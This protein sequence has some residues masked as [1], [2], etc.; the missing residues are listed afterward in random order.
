MIPSLDNDGYLYDEA[1]GI[2]RSNHVKNGKLRSVLDSRMT[3]VHEM[4]MEAVRLS[5]D[6]Y[7]LGSHASPSEPYSWLTFRGVYER[8]CEFAS[9]LLG[10]CSVKAN[11]TSFLGIYGRN[12]QDWVISE[13]ACC[14]YNFV[15][16][17]LYDTLG[18]EALRH[19][20]THAELSVCICVTV[21]R[22]RNLLQLQL[23]LLK[24]I[25]LISPEEIDALRA[26]AGP[27]IQVH[28][29]DDI[30][31]YGKEH[32]QPPSPSEPDE[33][34]L[35]CYTSGT[36]GLPKGV[37]VTNKMLIATV[38]G[39]MIHSDLRLFTSQD[40]HL[41]YLPLAHIFE[42]FATMLV[43]SG[44]GRIGF[45]AGDLTQLQQDAFMLQPTLF[46][47]VP[48][49]LAR[50]KQKVYRQVSGS[51]FKLS[52]LNTAINRKLKEVDRRIYHHNTIWDQLVFS[53]IRKSFGSRIRIV[54][55]AG[56]PISADLLQFTR[57]AFCCPVLEGYGS[58]E[59]CGAITSSM[60]GDLGGGHVGPP[61]PNCEIKLC[62][63]E[64]LDLVSSRDNRGEIC[65][66]GAVCTPGYYKNEELT[67]TLIDEDG[68]LHTGDVGTWLENNRLKIVDRRKHIFKL[69][70]GEYV[71]PEKI[72]HIYAQ[73]PYVHQIFVD[74]DA[75]R[76]YPVAI[77]VPEGEA[78][79]RALQ[80]AESRG[81]TLTPVA[82][83]SGTA[84][85]NN[86]VAPSLT[87]RDSTHWSIRKNKTQNTT[88][89]SGDS[90]TP[91]QSLPAQSEVFR[92]QNRDVTLA[93]L[94][95][96]PEATKIILNDLHQLGR[97][98]NLK[99]FEQVRA[100][101]LIHESFSVENRL[102]TPIMKCAR[103]AIRQR[104]QNE[105]QKLFTSGE[106]D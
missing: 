86:N 30:L 74:G 35:V 62:N 19:I 44:R 71:A 14:C 87:K 55:T 45:Y 12:T 26:D 37:I 98:A 79:A 5:A 25:I 31:N 21:D 102:L 64:E 69:S 67:K 52:L 24:H 28:S 10:V 65:C 68:W 53:K 91:G 101:F 22:A 23:P 83:A 82:S 60:F 40:V 90:G 106:L 93:E 61:M 54:I 100:L 70:Q 18:L 32:R 41:S 77:V 1:E 99:G 73:S 39:C 15:A 9:G 33:K 8:V 11:G 47:A 105:L 42:Q 66:R 57:A 46:I 50:I 20:C 95:L 17:P 94:C 92:L 36:T 104:Y 85:C 49:V 88:A 63:I 43:L 76:S 84:D 78:L 34:V 13:L 51:K 7:F 3:S 97:A 16:V 72:E 75:L 56:A 103:H 96:Y 4:L 48:R 27:A 89:P 80:D 29:F 59:T 6:K 81:E 38:T 2:R 58:T